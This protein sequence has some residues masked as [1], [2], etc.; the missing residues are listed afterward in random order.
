MT[1]SSPYERARAV[2]VVTMN[3]PEYRNAQN[4]AMTY[5]LDE[6]F[7]RAVD[8][9]EVE[10]IVLGRRRRALL[11]RP[12]HRH[13]GPRRR[14]VLRPQGR[15]VVGPRRQARAPTGASP[16]RS[17]V[18]LGM[19]RRWREIPKPTI[20]MVQGACIAGG[21]MLAWVCDL[22]VAA[23]DAFFAD[24][25]GAD[26]HPGRRVLRAP[27]GD[28]PARG[29]GDALHR[30]PVRRA[31]GRCELGHGQPRGARATSCESETFA[32][33]ER[34]AT[35][36]RFGLALTKKAVN[37]AEDLMGHARRAWTRS[38]ACTTSRTRTTPRSAPDSLGGHGR[39]VDE[40]PASERS[41]TS[42]STSDAAFR[43]EVR[44]WLAA[45]CPPTRCPRWTPPRASQ[46][47]PRVGAPAR[48]GAAGRWCRGRDEYGGR[49]ASLLEWLIFE[50]EYYA[51]RRAG[52]GQPE[53][54]LPAR[55]D[56][57]RRTAP[58]SSG[59]GSCRRWPRAERRLGAG[60]VRAG[61]GQR[62][63]RRS[64]AARDR[65]ATAAGC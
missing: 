18:Y 9:D 54:H 63:R 53:R 42:T 28:R 43:D 48:D 4:S 16:A 41:W 36:P 62:P 29:Q 61:G 17:E 23:D 13:P 2:A 51:R 64:A 58:T 44:D 47:A 37:Q 55:P 6:A 10:V 35:M 3:R 34:I 46:R 25:G 38:S 56:P 20:A 15:D 14:P 49:D 59:T 5:A 40:R 7:A 30:R 26:G 24:P 11:G 45:T 52:P 60:L 1:R 39:P 32:I 21:L 33:A 65:S 50:E 22:I 8:D 31:S 19:C 27:V 12:R 57:V